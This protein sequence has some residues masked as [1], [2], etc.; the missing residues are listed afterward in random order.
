[1]EVNL[2]SHEL[3]LVMFKNHLV[4][5]RC[6]EEWKRNTEQQLVNMGLDSKPG[7]LGVEVLGQELNWKGHGSGSDEL[8]TGGEDDLQMRIAKSWQMLLFELG[9]E[10]FQY[11][12]V[13]HVLVL[14]IRTSE[15]KHII[16]L[17]SSWKK[18]NWFS[19]KTCFEIHLN[20]EKLLTC[21]KVLRISC[22][23]YP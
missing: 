19:S 11:R 3:N 5:F 17:E 22:S 9:Y 16:I 2:E 1:M 12:L 18:N 8:L 4:L 23:R 14:L 21:Y 7:L 13:R 20:E 10:L 15:R 6:Y